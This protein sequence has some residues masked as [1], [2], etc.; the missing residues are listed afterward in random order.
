MVIDYYLSETMSS[1]HA[2]NITEVHDVPMSVLIRPFPP[3]VDEAKVNSLMETLS[4]PKTFDDVPPVD[5]L[6]IVGREG[7]NYYYS[8]G[9][10]H[11]YTAHKRLKLSYIRAKLVKSSMA[12]LK[13]YLGASTPDLK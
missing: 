11:R 4:D 12:D 13:C 7:G 2:A 10:C 8:F 5:V 9:G 1:I 3:E 6:W